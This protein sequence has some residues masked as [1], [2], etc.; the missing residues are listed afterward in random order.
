MLANNKNI[1]PAA[2]DHLH[3]NSNSIMIYTCLRKSN[4]ELHNFFY[5]CVVVVGVYIIV[6]TRHVHLHV[7]IFVSQVHQSANN[8]R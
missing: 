7:H 1:D 3:R 2:A 8:H 5:I 4:I 6:Y